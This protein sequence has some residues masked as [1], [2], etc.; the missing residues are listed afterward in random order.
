MIKPILS[1]AAVLAVLTAPAFAEGD[2]DKGEK[3][4]KK[5]KACHAVG[6]DAK[7]KVGPELNGIVGAPA[8]HNPDFKY[9]DAMKEAAEGGLVWDEESLAA[10]LTK[11]RDFMK[12]TKMT[13]AGLRKEADIANVIAYLQSF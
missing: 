1:T 9:S 7:N 6:P 2:A 3:V 12:G 10:F 8:M 13:F 5:C 11:P 4:F